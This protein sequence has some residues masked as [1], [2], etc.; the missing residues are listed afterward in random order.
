MLYQ[1]IVMDRLNALQTRK[2]RYY[3]TYQDAYNA[4]WKLA[5][6]WYLNTDRAGVWVRDGI[7][8]NKDGKE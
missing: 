5:H 3:K 2:T 8:T 1:G 7:P 6:R 4:A